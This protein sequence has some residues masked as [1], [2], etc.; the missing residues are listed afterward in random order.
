MTDRGNGEE[1]RH[2]GQKRACQEIGFAEPVRMLREKRFFLEAC[3]CLGE[4]HLHISTPERTSF[5]LI[6]TRRSRMP[7]ELAG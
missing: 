2:H 5:W 4:V 7:G 1:S 6:P 3:Q